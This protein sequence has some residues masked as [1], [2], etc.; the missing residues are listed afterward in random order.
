MLTAIN[1]KKIF[2]YSDQPVTCPKCGVRT[3]IILDL[4]HTIQQT[5]IHKCNDN[6]KFQ[7]VLQADLNI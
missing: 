5:Q 4:S 2:I 1:F 3:E 6:C 7:F